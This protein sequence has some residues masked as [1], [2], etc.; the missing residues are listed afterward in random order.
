[1]ESSQFHGGNFNVVAV[2]VGKNIS[3]IQYASSYPQKFVALNF[4]ESFKRYH[5]NFI[6][7]SLYLFATEK[8]TEPQTFPA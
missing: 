2:K 8:T 5:F 3:I 6:F 1:M 7:L 4:R